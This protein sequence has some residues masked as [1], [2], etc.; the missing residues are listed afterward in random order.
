MNNEPLDKYILFFIYD[1]FCE[2]TSLDLGQNLEK[3]YEQAKAGLFTLH[4]CCCSSTPGHRVIYTFNLQL[5]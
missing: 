1:L 4:L 3:C 5:V 2:D